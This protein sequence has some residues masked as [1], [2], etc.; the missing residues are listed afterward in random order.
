[1]A[2]V[3]RNEPCPCG[4]GKKFKKCCGV[5]PTTMAGTV[6]CTR[7]ER[8]AVLAMM[9]HYTDEL[10]VDEE[11]D[12]FAEMWGRHA[13]REDELPPDL[14]ALANDAHDAWFAFDYRLDDDTR[15]V[16]R[17]LA[18]AP[19]TAGQ[20]SYLQ[21]MRDST[22]RLYEVTDTVPGVS[23]TL[24]DVLDGGSVTVHERSGSRS[25]PR[26]MLL[27]ARVIPR[28]SSGGPEMEYGLLHIPD[29]YRG[30]IDA[31]R[32]HID[33][34]LRD[35]PGASRQEAYEDLPPLLFDAWLTS[36]F[37][38]AVPELRNFDGED[39]V[40]TRVSFRIE[41]AGALERAL[42]A[43]NAEGIEPTGAGR[44][45]WAGQSGSGKDV[46]FAML[47]VK[48]GTLTVEC[49]S[50]ARGERARALVERLARDAVLHRATTHEDVRRKVAQSVTDRALGRVDDEAPSAG[51]LDPAV[52]EGLVLQ[53]QAR[54]Y[55]SWVD[56]PV[57]ML[58][59]QTPRAAA[60]VSALRPRVEALLR[61]LEGTYERALKD[62]E[63][64][65]DPSWMWAELGLRDDA[66]SMSQGAPAHDRLA[67][68]VP[69]SAE[70]IRAAA[71]RIRARAGFDERATTVGEDDVRADLELQRFVR[72]E[73]PSAN[74]AGSDGQH[75]AP[76]L[77][78]LVNFELHRRKVLWVDG[79]LSF[80][81]EGTDLDVAGGELRVPFPSFALVL[82]DRHALGLGERLLA[83]RAGDPLRGQILRVATVYVT[84]RRGMSGRSLSVTFAFDALG[85]DLPSLVVFDVPAGD[86]DSL[87]AWLDTVAPL[88]VSDAPSTANPARALLRLVL[89]AVLYATSAS[90]T[91]DVRKPAPSPSPKSPP[92]VV[93][94]ESDSLYVLPGTID[95]RLVRRLKELERAPGGG[96]LLA[97]F[98]VRGHWRRPQKGWAD[99]R[100]RWI[101][102][103][104]KG[105]ELGAIIEK[106]YRLTP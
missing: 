65:Y 80:L 69:G 5:D 100:L 43:A 20:R 44:W 35:N 96:T 67:E 17:V 74:D 8:T 93:P 81:L 14:L 2:K 6:P 106:A 73:R 86:D 42:G 60:R 27:A 13:E 88:P 21:Q 24:S 102:P 7:A 57:P 62:G 101:A 29:L 61:D 1:M 22:M 70:A 64:A 51:A 15:V 85:S 11:E 71:D 37:E 10:L 50:V 9:D 19:L 34:F 41:D 79:A 33:E 97:R 53:L 68:R 25:M 40:L 105:P 92:E 72:R 23:V 58:D 103:Y 59:G 38:P 84:E 75:A 45:I 55:R 3:G 39:V 36:I 98:L 4:S 31:A 18:S 95:I 32:A 48:D 63:P 28:G 77:A 99:Q 83:R 30:V 89:N 76:Y 87:N 52:A 94:P 46:T 104:W 90:V 54:H 12:A 26:R 49:N 56:E 82:S 66:A 78:L 91:L 47:A 16:D